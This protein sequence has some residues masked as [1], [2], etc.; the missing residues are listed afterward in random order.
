MLNRLKR[1]LA[2]NLIKDIYCYYYSPLRLIRQMSL[3]SAQQ[4]LSSFRDELKLNNID[5]F[6]QSTNDA[7]QSEYVCNRDKRLEYY[8]VL[9][10]HQE[11]LL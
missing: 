4:R 5:C 6:I 10:D 1:K 7:H 11:Q 3:P 8:H 2:S 9:Q